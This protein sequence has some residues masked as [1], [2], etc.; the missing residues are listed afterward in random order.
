MAFAAKLMAVAVLSGMACAA[1]ADD[2]PEPV[3]FWNSAA[4]DGVV[5]YCGAAGSAATGLG[6]EFKGWSVS[7]Y[8]GGLWEIR[9]HEG[10]AISAKFY[11]QQAG[12]TCE[13][14]SA[15]EYRKQSGK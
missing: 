9:E 4:K 7:V 10:K 8:A 11:R 6:K 13:V 3:Q 15:E 1:Q 5:L 2:Y 12:E 14:F